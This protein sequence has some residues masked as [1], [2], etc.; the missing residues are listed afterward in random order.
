M[1]LCNC[2]FYPIIMAYKF[3]ERV[4]YFLDNGYW[5]GI[6]FL[7]SRCKFFGR[8]AIFDLIVR[9]DDDNQW[10]DCFVRLFWL[11]VMIASGIG[12]ATIFKFTL[13]NFQED[14]ININVETSY[15]HWRNTFPAVSMCLTK[16]FENIRFLR[17]QV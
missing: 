5:H 1:V 16:G 7:G 12:M 9:N 15:L 3:K 6:R 17:S 13:Q 10:G 11:I 14:V 8:F 4:F 2:A